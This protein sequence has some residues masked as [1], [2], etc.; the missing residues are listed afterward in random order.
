LK[1]RCQRELL[2][3]GWVEAPIKFGGGKCTVEIEVTAQPVDSDL[4]E[5]S[6][7]SA[8]DDLPDGVFKSDRFNG[9][10]FSQYS[11]FLREVESPKGREAAL[12]EESIQLVKLGEDGG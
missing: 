3:R 12:L 9:V 5:G 2:R 6:F 4:G 10:F 7:Y 1:Q 8:N 11:V